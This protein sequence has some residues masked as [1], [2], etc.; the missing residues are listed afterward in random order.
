M[1]GTQAQGR[2][3]I[4]ASSCANPFALL[5]FAARSGTPCQILVAERKAFRP[6]QDLPFS[7]TR[8]PQCLA[9]R[10]ALHHFT[11]ELARRR[12]VRVLIAYVVG[13]FGALQGLDIMVT[14][15]ERPGTWMRWAVL[16]AL[17]GLPAALVLSWIFD[18]TSE[19][20]V[21]TPPAA[22]GSR[23]HR[24]V[25]TSVLALLIGALAWFAIRDYRYRTARTRLD[26]AIRLADQG[27]LVESLALAF[28]L[29]K[30][31]P[32]GAALQKL[33]PEISRVL[34]VQTNPPGAV[35]QIHP[36]GASDSECRT[37][38]T[39]PVQ[40]ARISILPS[41]V[42]ITKEGYLPADRGL[43]RYLPF[44]A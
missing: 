19:G 31:L 35:V 25:T 9:V 39:T 26:E 21:R 22:Q 3:R 33:W 23:Q 43:W 37:L 36:Y 18:W 6:T 20:L 17:A 15:L 32:A 24:A 28:E 40:G 34:E 7:S 44:Q 10:G 4:S 16:L 27:K 30:A 1:S 8:C 29:E 5:E 13:V 42:R 2:R 12:V 41:Q 14:R 38:G 11:Q